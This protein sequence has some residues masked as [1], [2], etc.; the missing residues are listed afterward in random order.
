MVTARI[1]RRDTARRLDVLGVETLVHLS[2]ADTSGQLS[3][4]ELA[5][6]AGCGVPL[7][8]HERETEVFHVLEGTVEFNVGGNSLTAAAGTTVLAPAGN[9][10]S[11]CM[12]AA[13][14]RLLVSVTPAGIEGM[15]A[16]LADLPPGPP[17][18]ARVVEICG[19]HG[20]T[21]V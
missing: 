3:L 1:V 20:V 16:A 14:A 6:A 12:G 2:G 15:F 21:F 13:G 9:A 18:M 4:F 11:F 19:R 17:D 10:H 5:G 7:H 8:V